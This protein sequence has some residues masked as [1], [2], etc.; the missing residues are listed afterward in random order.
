MSVLFITRPDTVRCAIKPV[1]WLM[2]FLICFGLGYPTLNR[3]DPAKIPGL[4]DSRQY[5]QLV[6]AGP[7]KA[8]G[9]WRYRILVP[10]L[11]RPLYFATRGDLGSWNPVAFSMLVVNSAFCASS[12]LLLIVLAEFLSLQFVTGLIAA[13]SY[14][15]NSVV[16]NFQLAGLVDSA[17]SFLM[18]CIFLICVQRRW[19]LLPLIGVVGGLAKETIFPVAFLF[20]CGWATRDARKFWFWLG[21]M[22][23]AAMGTFVAV[24]SVIDGHLVNPLQVAAQERHVHSWMDVIRAVRSIGVD[25]SVWLAFLW[26]LP[27]AASGRYGLPVQAKV[28]TVLG[29]GGALAL[30]VWNGSGGNAVRPMFDVAAPYL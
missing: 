7:D 10:Y 19:V 8:E 16:G 13:F 12:A 30:S 22:A 4:S 26:L 24:H 5:F 25:W 17:E 21:A 6:V 28:G 3:Y 14:V 11:A 1:V 23:L 9:H 29:V 2:F 15:A 20:V 27:F 18:T